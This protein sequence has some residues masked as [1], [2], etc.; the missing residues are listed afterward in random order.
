MNLV[1][2]VLSSD[3]P[4]AIVLVRLMVGAVF[5]SE[6]AQKFLF[7]DALG[8]GRF[9]RIGIPYPEVLGPFVGTFEVTCGLLVL[10]GLL[11]RPAAVPLIVVMLVA[12]ASTKVPILRE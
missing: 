7:P 6:G 9:A 1:R 5:M 10:V 11:T 2:R 4:A 3:A 12:I 8:A